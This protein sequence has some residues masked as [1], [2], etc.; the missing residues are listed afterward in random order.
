[1]SITI[2]IPGDSGALALGAD[3]VAKAIEAEIATRGIDA[4]VVRNGSRGAYFLEPM[5]EV[6]TDTGRVAYGPV[7][8]QG[9]A[10]AV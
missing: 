5:V 3:K 4:K 2:Y 7:I 9:R 10:I 1:M 8:G 6:T